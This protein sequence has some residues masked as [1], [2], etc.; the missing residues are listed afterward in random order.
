MR[1]IGLQ[2]FGKSQCGRESLLLRSRLLRGGADPAGA[3]DI[4]LAIHPHPTVPE[5]FAMSAEARR[6]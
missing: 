6:R 5:T 1:R 3:E 2:A 4:G